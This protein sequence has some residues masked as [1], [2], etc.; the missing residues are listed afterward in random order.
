MALERASLR[1]GRGGLFGP[2]R[3]LVLL[4]AAWPAAVGAD[5]ARRT[6]VVAL[7]AGTLRI[8]VPDARWRNVLHRMR[9]QILSQLRATAGDLAPARLGF[10]EASTPMPELV[11]LPTAAA[12]EAPRPSA[13]PPPAVVEAAAAIPDPDLRARFIESAGRYLGRRVLPASLPT[14]AP[15]DAGPDPFGSSPCAKP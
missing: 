2:E 8:R 7:E 6:E 4:R 3:A 1:G 9:V 13:P 10:L 11:A 5:L 14:A 15:S 12:P